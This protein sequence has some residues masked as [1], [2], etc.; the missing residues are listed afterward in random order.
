ME[1]T[2][3]SSAYRRLKSPNIKTRKRAL[4]I[5]K[6]HKQNKMKKLA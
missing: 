4:K 5:I 6:E 1:K 2:D 3:I